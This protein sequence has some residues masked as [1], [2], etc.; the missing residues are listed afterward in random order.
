MLVYIYKTQNCII[1]QIHFDNELELLRS[2]HHRYLEALR[3]SLG[4]LLITFCCTKLWL[5]PHFPYCDYSYLIN[6]I[7]NA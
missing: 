6:P 1:L 3:N 2:D 5:Q 7:F 4:D